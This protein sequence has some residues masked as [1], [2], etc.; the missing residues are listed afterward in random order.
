VYPHTQLSA[1]SY[2][3]DGGT[4]Y[5]EENIITIK[6][7]M[8]ETAILSPEPVDHGLKSLS[9]KHATP[10]QAKDLLNF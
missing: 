3:R 6:S 9:G 8:N 5:I 10:E 7:K 2:T 1:V 4:W